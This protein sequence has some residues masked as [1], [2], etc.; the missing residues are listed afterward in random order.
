MNKITLKAARGLKE[1]TQNEMAEK[2]GVSTTTYRNYE[3]YKNIMPVTTAMLFSEI[4]DIP[5]K[6]LIFFKNNVA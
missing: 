2:L 4:V 1:L 6:E 5:V 3:T